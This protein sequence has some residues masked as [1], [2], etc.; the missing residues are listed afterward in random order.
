ML[1][2]PAGLLIVLSVMKKKYTIEQLNGMLCMH[3]SPGYPTPEAIADIVPYKGNPV[4]GI[5][6]RELWT[7]QFESGCFTH[8][9]DEA[10]QLLLTKGECAYT[11]A[12]GFTALEV[13]EIL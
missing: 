4:N 10:L 11:R 6:N 12:A 2:C 8:L 1:S 13:I 5:V 7:V 3:G 9:T